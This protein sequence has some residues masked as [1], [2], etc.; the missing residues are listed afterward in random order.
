MRQ[1]RKEQDLFFSEDITE[2]KVTNSKLPKVQVSVN[3]LDLGIFLYV[4]K[5][6]ILN[7]QA[8]NKLSG[9]KD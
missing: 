7:D 9:N 4:V 2:T 8:Y 1:Q 6:Y 3:M 5:Q